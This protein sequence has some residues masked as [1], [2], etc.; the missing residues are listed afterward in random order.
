MIQFYKI[1]KEMGLNK[2]EI[3]KILFYKNQRP[4]LNSII[5]CIILLIILIVTFF[6]LAVI[7][8][9]INVDPNNS[10]YPS[11]TLYSTVKTRDFKNKR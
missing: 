1:G 3:N 2:K 8:F 5:V 7:T 9:P 11:G 6:A 4:I 10:T